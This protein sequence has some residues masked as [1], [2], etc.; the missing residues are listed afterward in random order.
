M[1]KK[2]LSIQK[3]MLY[4]TIGSI[5]Y[6]ACQWFTTVVIVHI[7]GYAAAGVLSLAM[8]V[9]A[10]PAIIG[11]FNVRNYQV[12][13]LQGKYSTNVYLKSRT[14]TNILSYILCVM[15]VMSSKYSWDK[16]SVILTFML[17]KLVE[18]YADVYYG[19]EQRHGYLCNVGISLMLRGIGSIAIFT[20]VLL[21][22]DQLLVAI[23]LMTIYSL[24]IIWMYDRKIVCLYKEDAKVDANG[25]KMT[26]NL[27]ITC[28]PLAMVAFLNNLSFNLP[29]IALENFYGEEA[30]GYYSSVASPTLVVQLATS[31]IFAPLIAPLTEA[32]NAG[33]KKSFYRIISRFAALFVGVAVVCLSGAKFLAHWGLKLV[34]GSK[35]EPYVYLF[36][37]IIGVTILLALNSS[38]FGICTLLRQIKIQYVIGIVGILSSAIAAEVIVKDM[39][40]MGTV[41]AQLITIALQTLIQLIIIGHVLKKKWGNINE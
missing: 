2:D 30:M 36:L 41:Y 29:K 22:V 3:Q 24:G 28:F 35:I 32:F 33:D 12:S 17:Y 8:S 4:Y 6:Y 25:W 40:L 38:L 1:K 37:P 19:V 31:T 9:T 26:I 10:A 7:S 16:S 39:G 15:V 20:G 18:G 14:Y 5:I 34:F 11:L 21:C 27:L 23:I 13:D